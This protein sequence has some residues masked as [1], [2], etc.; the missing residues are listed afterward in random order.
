MPIFDIF[1][2]S[3]ETGALWRCSVEGYPEAVFIMQRLAAEK[4]GIYFVFDLQSSTVVAR[5]NTSGGPK[6]QQTPSN[7][8]A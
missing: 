1:S 7:K 4:P 2:G 5:I 8:A 3:C 6:P